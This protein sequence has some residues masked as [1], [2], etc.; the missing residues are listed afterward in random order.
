LLLNDAEVCL[1]LALEA[2]LRPSCRRYFAWRGSYFI[3]A[4]TVSYEYSRSR[5]GSML[6]TNARDIRRSSN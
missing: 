5:A 1:S 6:P 3:L 2:P 4:R